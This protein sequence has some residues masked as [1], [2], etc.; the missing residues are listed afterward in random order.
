M[1]LSAFFQVGFVDW[2]LEIKVYGKCDSLGKLKST[3]QVTIPRTKLEAEGQT[4][5]SIESLAS[6]EVVSRYC[7]QALNGD[8]YVPEVL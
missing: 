5:T 2:C 8:P 6:S 3:L 4:S 1:A 7:L